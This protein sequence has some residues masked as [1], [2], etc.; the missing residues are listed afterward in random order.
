MVLLDDAVPAL[1][2]EHKGAGTVRYMPPEVI[3]QGRIT[4]K[5]NIY[6]CV[7]SSRCLVS[8]RRGAAL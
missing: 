5:A 7:A 4:A 2:A 8:G 3:A 1:Y 6:R